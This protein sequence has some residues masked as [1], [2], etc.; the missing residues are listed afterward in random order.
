M[1]VKACVNGYTYVV[2]IHVIWIYVNVHIGMYTY[3]M[4]MWYIYAVYER[5]RMCAYRCV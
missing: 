4:M 5:I 1:N 2:K 3:I